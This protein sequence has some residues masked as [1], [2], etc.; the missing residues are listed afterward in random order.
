MFRT[1]ANTSP[2]RVPRRCMQSDAHQM[3]PIIADVCDITVIFSVTGA[4]K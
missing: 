2:V 4:I 3:E 1:P